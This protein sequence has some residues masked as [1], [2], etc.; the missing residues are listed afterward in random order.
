MR[1]PS[2]MPRERRAPRTSG[3]GRIILV[4]V[5]VALFLLATSLR[6]IA[7]FYTDFLW[8][9]ALHQSKVWSG[10]LGAK[11]ALGLIFTGVFF[12][13]M[14]VNLFIADR[15]APRF[16]PAGPEEDLIERYHEIVGTHTGLVRVGVS[17]LFALITG[18]GV[19]SQWNEWILFTHRVDFGVKDP[20][21]HTDVGFYVFQLPFL[22]YV[23]NWLFAAFVVILIVT[24]VSH[25]LNGGIRVQ[26]PAPFQRVTP[27][28]KAHLSVLLGVLA[29]VKAA[30]YWLQRYTLTTST[31][32]TVDGA[33]YTD[34][35]AQLP[36]IYLLLMISLFAFFLFLLN[37]FRRG[38]VLP[39]L[40]VGLW[41]F[42]AV[43][44]GGIVPAFIQRFSVQPAESTKEALYIQRNIAATRVALG[45]KID[46]TEF[47]YQT[48][49]TGQQALEDRDTLE[50]V[51]L[52]EPTIVGDTYQ[53]LQGQRP[54]YRFCAD[55]SG[56]CIGNLDV[57]R[58][59]LDGKSTQVVLAARELNPDG[60]PQKSWLG[61]H[62][63]YTHGYGVAGAQAN[64]ISADGSPDFVVAG[65][66][67][68]SQESALEIDRPELYFGENL[69]GYSIVGTQQSEE[70]GTGTPTVYE[71][72][73]GVQM[74]GFVRKA[75]FALRFGDF[76]PL[77]SSQITSD[78]RILYVRDVRERAQA[79]APF[80]KFDA[81][82]YPVVLDGHIVWVVDGYT[83][84]DRFPYGQRANTDQL[85]PASDL[86]GSRFNYIRNSV[87]AVVDAYNGTVTYYV[88][89]GPAGEIDPIIRAYRKA[90]PSL[91][92][93][94]SDMPEDLLPHL[95]YPEELFRVQTNMWG[96]YQLTDPGEFYGFAAGWAVAQDPGD[97]VNPQL[98]NVNQSGTSG[99]TTTEAQSG[100]TQGASGAR[101]APYY[102][103]LTLPGESE[104]EFVLMRPFVKFSR[105]DS[106]RELTGFM[107]A[108]C[109][110]GH[111]GE[112]IVYRMPETA[113]VPGPALVA[114]NIASNATISAQVSLLNQQ[115]SRIRVGMYMVPVGDTIVYV[116]PL[117]VEADI[118]GAQ[119]PELRRVIVVA[120]GQTIMAPTLREAL[121]TIF[122]VE[123]DTGEGQTG[124]PP[125]EPP[126][127]P[128]EPSDTVS[129][130]LDQAQELFA[131]ADAALQQ[132]PPDY[133]TWADK[134]Q[135]ARDLVAQ[136]QELASAEA[137]GSTTTTAP[138]G[139]S[140]TTTPT[141]AA[142]T[143]T[144]SA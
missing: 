132:T 120:N 89:P 11:I 118:N 35:H 41:A 34:I 109:D 135:Q 38:W 58:Y 8:F 80:L 106:R 12:V 128:T 1:P 113:V 124:G 81:D 116:R 5:A 29:L 13:L 69:G 39:V 144:A 111:Y 90:F 25:Y 96:R 64:A 136:A 54:F 59:L 76:N 15:L 101:M 18:A 98:G 131:E 23:V 6:G 53:N 110:P 65:V 126:P 2:D 68:E 115:G 77:I 17:L 72:T 79:L 86:D 62:L 73:G 143:T 142:T 28:V 27:Q 31:R 82:P 100:V 24:T 21:F 49:I 43:V 45:M 103:N 75:A 4:V 91:F 61:Q 66:P 105:D 36:A 112:L 114:S 121:A 70:S 123:V 104:S 33:T 88:M 102:A 10:I 74:S 71:G 117:Y 83:T 134:F 125:T 137:G 63:V 85:P 37:I 130:L 22:T 127:G 46:E 138:G 108:R 51:R 99:P 32:G 47:D 48:A 3:R 92:A 42:V 19:S 122:S 139:A 44:A 141:T 129:E 97:T 119:V 9:Q 26:T 78:S 140:T 20:L 40:A 50:N 107:V 7:R 93:D 52:L 56:N 94:L 16:R 60:V 67:V 133:A 87:K 30:G 95:R 55:S 14:W 57:D 84:S